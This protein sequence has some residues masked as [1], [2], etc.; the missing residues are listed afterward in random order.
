M[1]EA[2]KIREAVFDLAASQIDLRLPELV[3]GYARTSAPPVPYPTAC[4]PQAWDAAALVY[5][6]GIRS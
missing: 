6:T 1:D 3:G 2:K 5:L 4:R